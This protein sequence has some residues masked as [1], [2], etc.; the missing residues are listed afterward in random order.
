MK[1]KNI[2][3]RINDRFLEIELDYSR[4]A[5]PIRRSVPDG[6]HTIIFLEKIFTASNINRYKDKLHFLKAEIARK[7]QP[8]LC[9]LLRTRERELDTFYQTTKA[10]TANIPLYRTTYR[11]LEE[12]NR[13]IKIP[14]LISPAVML[15]ISVT[16]LTDNM[17]KQQRIQYLS[18]V[19]TKK[20]FY[21]Q[22]QIIMKKFT[23]IRSA[24]FEVEKT[25]S[26]WIQ[27][28]RK[29]L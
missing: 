28:V 2:D 1:R 9:D 13:I 25:H 16:A 5:Y 26:K 27:N 15:F 23:H 7:Y 4:S 22:R 19:I 29:Q 8:V 6:L 24:I 20:D 11:H 14:V 3:L 17:I 10:E 12:N 18:G 21:R